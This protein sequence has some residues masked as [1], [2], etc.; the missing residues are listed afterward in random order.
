MSPVNSMKMKTNQ[1][2][3]WR[4]L[5]ELANTAEFQDFITREFPKGAMENLQG[6]SRRK[7]LQ[8]MGA[9]FALAGLTSCR[10]PKEKIVPYASRPEHRTP[11][12]PQYYATAMEING[13]GKPLVVTSYDGRPIKVEGNAKHPDC[14]GGSDVYAQASILELYDPDRLKTVLQ[15][16]MDEQTGEM[17]QAERSWDDFNAVMVAWKKEIQQSQGEG[18]CI[19]G[20]SSTSSLSLR[21]KLKTLYPRALWLTYEPI[22]NDHEKKAFQ[23]IYG[24]PYQ[25]HH[26][27]KQANLIVAMDCDFLGTHPHSQQL[28]HDFIEGRKDPA[29]GMNRLYVFESRYSTTGSMADHRFAVPSSSIEAILFD[30]LSA[31]LLA[32]SPKLPQKYEQLRALFSAHTQ[33]KVVQTLAGDL[34]KNV[35][36]SAILVGANQPPASHIIAGLINEILENTQR[37]SEQ[38]DCPVYFTQSQNDEGFSIDSIRQFVDGVKNGTITRALLLGGNPVYTAPAD[39]EITEALKNL[40]C[41]HLTLHAN[42]TSALCQWVLPRSHY[43]ESWDRIDFEHGVTIAQPLI[44]PLYDSRSSLEL[45]LRFIEETPPSAYE[46]LKQATAPEQWRSVL[47]TGYLAADQ[48]RHKQFPTINLEAVLKTVSRQD[49]A[50]MSGIEVTFYPDPSVYDGRYINNAWLQELPDPQTK[51]TWGNAALVS[52][53][54]A[55]KLAIGHGD[56]LEV[57]DTDNPARKLEIPVYVQPGQASNSIAISLGYGQNCPDFTVGHDVGC[58]AYGL[59]LSNATYI[60]TQVTVRKTGKKTELACTQDHH[61]IDRVG[62]EGQQERLGEIVREVDLHALLSHPDSALHTSKHKAHPLWQEHEYIGYK[63]GMAIDL[64]RCIGCNTCV[65]ACQAENNIPVV[66]Q[67]EVINGREMHWMRVDRYYKG[68]PENPEIV[69]QPMACHH[70]ENAPCEQVCPVAATVHS[71]EGLNAMVYNRCVGTRYCS[72]NCPLKVRRFNFFNYWKELPDMRKMQFNPEVTV[73]SRGVMEKCTFC[74]QRIE[75]AKI[76]AKNERRT[77]QD[78]EVIPACAQACPTQAIVF[79]DLNDPGSQVAIRQSDPRSYSLLEEIYLKSRTGYLAKV[80][81]PNPALKNNDEYS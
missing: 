81:N 74:V 37:D 68:T 5:H 61:A 66:G 29:H 51:I 30:L 44:D 75:V 56:I 13:V 42:E 71:E 38:H 54:D 27:L 16:T 2:K 32:L 9:S 12:I 14:P 39:I 46:Y 26:N 17:I 53:G 58:N 80:R 4:S 34:I 43:L 57:S 49:Q 10:W 33:N 25:I 77:L 28:A 3:Y 36:K 11:G 78:S 72:N 60:K 47:H 67:E 22:H 19:L 7:F 63:W 41:A 45:W 79:G 62:R 15:R 8:I 55:E 35:G 70:C 20:E 31:L 76:K 59:R 64:N 50:V 40:E 65:I 23:Q 24:Q 73:R 48:E 6:S 1:K 69:H 18:F 52:P 21:K